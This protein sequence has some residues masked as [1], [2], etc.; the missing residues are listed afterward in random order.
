MPNIAALSEGATRAI[1]STLVLSDAVSVT[2]ELIDNALDSRATNIVIEISAN[3]LD[4]I[5][6]KDNGTGIGVEDRQLLCKR[7]YT[8][9]I[10]TF[11]DLT[12]L[13]GSFLGFRG[14]ALASIAA[15][16]QSVQVT[17][18]VDGEVVG[19]QLKFDAAGKLVGSSSASHGTGTTIRV[20]DFL[21]GIPVRR[22]TAVKQATKTLANVK[23]LLFD[24]AFARPTVRFQVKVLKSKS[25]F[26]DNWSYAP[27]K[28]ATNL[29]LMTSKISGKDLAGQCRQESISSE[30]GYYHID[31]FVLAGATD[32]LWSHSTEQFASIDGRPLIADRGFMKDVNKIYKAYLRNFLP[33]KDSMPKKPFL[34]L[35]LQCPKGAYDV[36]VEPAKNEVLLNDDGV[37]LRLFD[38][39]CQRVY[40]EKNEPQPPTRTRGGGSSIWDSPSFEMLLA[41][42]PASLG[43]PS[44]REEQQ[45]P[46]PAT[47]MR[48]DVSQSLRQVEN[49][50]SLAAQSKL[51]VHR[52]MYDQL[53]DG[54]GTTE[55]KEKGG[56]DSIL[57]KEMEE[58][59][60]MDPQVTNPFTLAKV[61]ARVQPRSQDTS[62][63]LDV[64]TSPDDPTRKNQQGVLG[65][66]PALRLDAQKQYPTELPSPSASPERPLLYRNPGPP[67]RPWKKGTAPD[68]TMEASTP[69]RPP[70]DSTTQATHPTLLDSWTKSVNT[71]SLNQH[72]ASLGIVNSSDPSEPSSPLAKARSKNLE[73][74]APAN[75][76]SNPPRLLQQRPF[77][78]PFRRDI[79]V[80]TVSP[81]QNPQLPPSPHSTPGPAPSNMS[82]SPSRSPRLT[83][84]E[85]PGFSRPSLALSTELDDIMDFEH[86]KR[87]SILQHRSRH[88]QTSTDTS[89]AG[90]MSA[91]NVDSSNSLEASA[92]GHVPSEEAITDR[93]SYASRFASDRTDVEDIPKQPNSASYT[94][95]PL[96]NRYQKSI[97]SL[98]E[99][100]ENSS[101]K[102]SARYSDQA[103]VQAL[104][105]NSIIEQRLQ[106]PEKQHDKK[107]RTKISKLPFEAISAATTTYTLVAVMQDVGETKP[108]NLAKSAATMA[109]I[110]PY[111]T[112]GLIDL[113]FSDSD[114]RQYILHTYEQDVRIMLE[115]R[116]TS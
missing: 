61:N 54:V 100:I 83:G 27:C 35:R 67:L 73:R 25:D 65:H 39:L 38:N 98:D 3:T 64:Q 62:N 23:R 18:R 51:N 45:K 22:Q 4:T 99:L 44:P 11:E 92:V 81:V 84:P 59:S 63:V 53:H 14:E 40:G 93:S 7:G 21:Q 42:K 58:A 6:L 56:D 86:R 52:N 91:K 112:T 77:R 116:K 34:L 49:S 101:G 5:Q 74:R 80:R 72:Q 55:D 85:L 82:S 113:A 104:E 97:R 95:N 114:S 2:K 88:R 66:S 103:R 69:L 71:S 41:K 75:A 10:R 70:L 30:D 96:Q 9:K 111:I 19:T 13:G 37:V 94:Q 106:E 89:T 31:A 60:V 16:S 76:S 33:V 90:A 109:H 12:Q 50:S 36:N 32:E 28:D 43:T 47:A 48:D 79:D 87:A 1:T 115:R 105:T 26:K 57:T 15:L 110:D 78:T 24:Y 17:T 102:E 107:G 20:S 108:E 46:E 8:S 29:A 68:S